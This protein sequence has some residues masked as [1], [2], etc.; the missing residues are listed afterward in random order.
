MLGRMQN[1]N[2]TMSFCELSWFKR[3]LILSW[4]GSN[5]KKNTKQ[6]PPSPK[7]DSITCQ[8]QKEDLYQAEEDQAQEEE[9]AEDRVR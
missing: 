5:T 8:A 6:G 1:S 3:E 7:P 2:L 4:S 9:G